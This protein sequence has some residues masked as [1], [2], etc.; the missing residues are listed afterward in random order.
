MGIDWSLAR[1]TANDLGGLYNEARLGQ[2]TYYDN[3]ARAAVMGNQPNFLQRIFGMTGP[4]PAPQPQGF[5]QSVTGPQTP[6]LT[7]PNNNQFAAPPSG[8]FAGI[9]GMQEVDAPKAPP[10]T[11]QTADNTIDRIIKV[12]SGGNPNAA[13]PN[14]TA[15]GPGQFI[16]TT[17]LSMIKKH[18]PDIAAGRSDQ[19]LL[20]LR[21]NPELSRQM[22]AA[23]AA[24]NNS[25][26]TNA[27]FQNTPGNTY[28]AHFAGPAGATAVLRADPNTPVI[29]V[30]GPQVVQA[31][32]FLANMNAGQLRQWAD[33][34]MGGTNQQPMQPNGGTQYAQNGPMQF[35]DQQLRTMLGSQRY[36]PV[37]TQF[38]AQQRS[39]Q[40][41]DR[42]YQFRLDESRRNQENQD[43]TYQAQQ[44]AASLRE[45]EMP[46]GSKQLVRILKDGS[47]QAVNIPNV[48]G[49]NQA[50]NP[51]A[52][53][54]KQTNDQANA[55]LYGTRMA[56][57]HAIIN[58]LEN[59]NKGFQGQVAGTLENSPT[60]RDSTLFNNKIGPERQQLIQAKRDFLNATLRRESGAVISDSEFANGNRQ[61]FPQPGD[62]DEVIAQKRANRIAAIK[63]IMGAATKQYKP[64]QSFVDEVSGTQPRQQQQAPAIPDIGEIRQGYRFKGG[65]P[66]DQNAWEPAQ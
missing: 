33:N 5:L 52:P 12:E 10:R 3:Q 15:V 46:D 37:A 42:D 11:T 58:G 36:A 16:T 56:N 28:L 29:N 30:L 65:N 26:L 39:Q 35:N 38:M 41:S 62:S 25:T 2:E 45:V 40:N 32:P 1:A 44:D 59:L 17:W 48:T 14:S 19:E 51:F 21:T 60:V 54:G 53:N 61:Y 4:T 57:S 31:N 23:Y 7:Q 34:K 6:Q 47:A 24:E 49:V 55:A 13:N 22:T 18:R 50:P 20:S 9:P 64:P 43:R 8:V 66:A 63:G 27:G